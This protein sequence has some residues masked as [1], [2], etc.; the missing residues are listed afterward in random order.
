MKFSELVH[1]IP[2]RMWEYDVYV[3]IHIESKEFDRDI[4]NISS[5]STES[6]EKL[7]VL[8]YEINDVQRHITLRTRPIK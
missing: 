5:S 8:R 3:M 4:I 2:A 1:T 7:E 6:W